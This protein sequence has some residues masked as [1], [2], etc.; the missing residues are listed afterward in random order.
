MSIETFAVGQR[1][2]DGPEHLETVLGDLLRCDVLLEGERV[3]PAELTSISVRRKRVVGTGC[4]VAATLWR[5]VADEDAPCVG[6]GGQLLA[7]VSDVQDEMLRS[8]VVGELDRLFDGRGFDDDAFRYGLA[9][10]VDSGEL[11][12]LGVDLGL[13]GGEFVGGEADGG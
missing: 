12:S 2:D 7:R 10:D 5:V 6:D 1:R 13:D 4:V 9:D 8:V 11:A 3:D